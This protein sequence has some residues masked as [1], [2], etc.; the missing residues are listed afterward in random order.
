[1]IRTVLIDD[2]LP[3]IETLQWK[4]AHYCKDIEVVAT[5]TDPVQ[6]IRYLKSHP[7]D[8]LFLDIEMPMMTGFDVL[9]ELKGHVNFDVIFVTAHNSFGIKAVKF[10]ALDYILKPV[11]NKELMSAVEKYKSGLQH[12]SP[13]ISN[14]LDN[15]E[16]ERTKRPVKIALA[17]KETIEFVPPSE[18]ILCEAD[19]NYTNVYLK[20]GTKRFI[21]KTLKDF[22]DILIPSGFFRPH[23]SYVINLDHVREFQRGDGGFI[24]MINQVE[25]PVAK[26]RRNELLTLLRGSE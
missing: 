17:S 14:L 10:S 16:A 5:F 1:M 25:V 13:G 4:L 22:E 7:V 6:G 15:L 9:E 20:D 2:E 3:S 24:V 12:P 8:L 11:H 21:S 23:N 26:N 18:I 19:S